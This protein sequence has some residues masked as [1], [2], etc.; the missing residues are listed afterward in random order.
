[1]LR[2]LTRKDVV[3][4]GNGRLLSA[5]LDDLGRRGKP[6]LVSVTAAS[7]NNGIPDLG[8]PSPSAKQL[9][10]DDLGRRSQGLKSDNQGL[11]CASFTT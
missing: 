3:E 1:M 7:T 5:V 8:R 11:K 10:L 2:T 9:D 4:H 6:T